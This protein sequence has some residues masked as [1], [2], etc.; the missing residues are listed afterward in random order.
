MMEGTTD[1]IKAGHD[2]RIILGITVHFKMGNKKAP[3]EK[4]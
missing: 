3:T 2:P 1:F 4:K